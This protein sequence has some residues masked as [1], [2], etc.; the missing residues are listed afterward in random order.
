MIGRGTLIPLSDPKAGS[1]VRLRMFCQD[2]DMG[3]YWFLVSVLGSVL[4]TSCGGGAYS[5]YMTRSYT[6]RGVRYHPMSVEQALRYKETGIA[7]WYDESSFLGFKRGRT[8]LGEKVGRF[9]VS[10]AHKTLPLPCQVRVTNLANGKSIKMRLNDRGPFIAG[11]IIDVTPR[12]ASKLGFKGRG[13]ARVR[14]E[15]LS[16]GDGRYKRKHSKGIPLVPFF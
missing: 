9:A 1:I 10:G 6:I 14:V 5:G 8:S 15:C 13:L 12:A 7:S 16:V 11:R 2:E 3:K 4:L